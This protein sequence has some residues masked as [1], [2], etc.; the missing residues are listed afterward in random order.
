MYF[1]ID[2]AIVVSFLLL[3]LYVGI[4]HSTRIKTIEG[5]A[6]GGRSFTTATIVATIAATWIGGSNLSITIAETYQ[7]GVLFLACSLAE[8]VSFWFIAYFYAPRMGE[9]LG[10]LSV[11]DAMYSVYQSR[12]TRAIIAAFST[13]P[14]IGR[15]AMQ[16]AILQTIL[17][18]WL[19]M[20]GLYATAVSSLI[21]ITYSSFGG[22]K[23]VTFT[24]LI[25]FF[26]FGVV[27]PMV[28]FLIWQS[29][30]DK[31]LIANAVITDPLFHYNTISNVRKQGLIDTIYL[32][33]FL[34]VPLLD[35][36]IFQRISMSKN[37]SQVSKSFLIA[38]FFILLC[39]ALVHT[40][41]GVLFRADSSIVDISAD[42][43]IQYII[44]H[45]LHYG[46]RGIF[47]VGIMSMIMSTADS[48]IN[49]SA[50]LVSYDLPKAFG[51]ELKEKQQLQLARFCSLVI[52]IV[53][54]SVSFFAKNLLEL[55][56]STYSFYMPIITLPFTLAIFGFRTSSRA[57]LIS[58]AAGFCTV[59]YFEFFSNEYN[60]ISG[61]PATLT[62]LIFLIGSHY[63]LGEN[64][65]WIGIQKQKQFDALILEKK[66][67]RKIFFSS[68]KIFDLVKFC[69]K[70][71]PK[72]E[73][74]FV[75][76]GLFCTITIFSNA[77]SLPHNLQE[78]YALLLN[79]IFYS[80]LTSST[81]FI[82]YPIWL[83][84][85]KYPVFISLLWN[86]TVFY[87]LSFSTCLLS[88]IGQFNQIQVAVL[89]A[90][91]VTI[92]V[93]MR[94]QITLVIIVC[95]V[96]MSIKSY[97]IYNGI[98]FLP[99]YMQNLQF[100]ITYLLLLV[101]GILIAF[102]KPKQQYQEL[103][104]EQNNY[105]M[106]KVELQKAEIAKSTELKNNFLRNV[107]HESN[108]SLAPILGFSKMLYEQYHDLSED[109]RL[110][111]VKYIADSS[112][113]LESLVKNIFDLSKL[114]S[115]KFNLNK[116]PINISDLV[117]ASLEKCRRLFI[118][119]CDSENRIWD[120][121]IEDNIIINC[122]EYYIGQTVDNLIKN[123]I[124]YCKKGEISITLEKESN[125]VRLTVSDEGVGIPQQEMEAIFD[126]F[127]TSSRTK[128]I[129]CG[130]GIGLTLAQKVIDLHDG[131][132]WVEKNKEKGSIFSLLFTI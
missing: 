84:K 22:I 76:F 28:A 73:R 81:I 116:K 48:Y 45:Y 129:G 99:E 117:Y 121:D 15:V 9:F 90:S 47:I 92:A 94:W 108:N 126:P 55:L 102:F 79:P 77:Y 107:P 60:I 54:L 82:T 100:K 50:V 38:I 122:D 71:T 63:I 26:T 70:N 32:C 98:S 93:L 19:G 75:Y 124:Q 88:I 118:D 80:V 59:V 112:N 24:D 8:A 30:S 97:K 46:L 128:K 6:L 53:A 65:G 103:T 1:N 95:G 43:V 130:R 7:H 52:G 125:S 5:Y 37:T 113:K 11:A 119:E 13:I 68:I 72:E 3:T 27:T 25:Q 62:S 106:D 83:K 85:F 10:K 18:L 105:L 110:E 89:M 127:V 35:P 123:A 39:D 31:E 41:I 57:L 58:M 21:I 16:F 115:N 4:R 131:V 29:F 101:S 74:I 40:F 61:I 120:I 51:I 42:N 132:I 44:D 14:A 56:L 96:I 64:G 67:R 20:P 2:V 17:N 91:L 78:Q 109:R 36:A 66:R 111:M 86:I 114:S 23:A 49:S 87:N 33:L 34:M 69:Q 104:D 12:Y